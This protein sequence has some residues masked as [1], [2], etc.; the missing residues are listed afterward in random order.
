M[1]LHSNS[2]GPRSGLGYRQATMIRDGL[3]WLRISSTHWLRLTRLGLPYSKLVWVNAV[4]WLDRCSY[5]QRG[6]LDDHSTHRKVALYM[7]LPNYSLLMP[8]KHTPTSQHTR[9]LTQQK[10]SYHKQDMLSIIDKTEMQYLQR[11]DTIFMRR[12]I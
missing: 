11:S 7:T 1:H 4:V 12:W 8:H 9:V 2:C 10:L 5:G 6:C 3:A